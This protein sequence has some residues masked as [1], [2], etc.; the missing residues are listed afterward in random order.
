MRIAVNTR[1]LIPDKLEGIGWFTYETMKRITRDHPEH[2]FIFLFDRQF[3]E[4]FIFSTNIT[5]VVV[6][7]PARHPLLWYYWFEFALPK[8]LKKTQA[9]IFISPDGNLSLRSKVKTM[10]VIHDLAFEHFRDQIP[11]SAHLFLKRYTPKYA[12]KADRIATVSQYSKDDICKQYDIFPD[13][14]DVVYNGAN[15]LFQPLDASQKQ[16]VKDRYSHGSDYFIYVGSIHPRKNVDGL[17][18][19]FDDFKKS[20]NNNVRLLIAG[21][22]AWQTKTTEQIIEKMHHKSDV[23]FTGHLNIKELVRCV[24][25]ALAMVYPSYFEGFGIPIVEAMY[26]DVPVITSNTSSM[27]EVGGE[28][29]LIIDP[30]STDSI[31]NAMLQLHEDARFRSALI[32]KGRNHRNRFSWDR[33]AERFWNSI[34]KIG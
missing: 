34:E 27:P 31:K 9:D 13:K 8:V 11:R 22:K 33:T 14:I 1:F 12:Q 29:A 6:N 10:L 7:P 21:R 3:D 15:E 25:G 30:Y 5:P 17:L 26:C 23:I 32:E 20:R 2:E 28:A 18:Q 4:Q 24:G 19:A 16:A